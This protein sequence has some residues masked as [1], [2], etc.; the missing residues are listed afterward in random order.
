MLAASNDEM[1]R[2]LFNQVA[3]YGGLL[4]R[5][6]LII[7]NEFRPGNS[8]F[9]MPDKS[10]SFDCLIR[11]LIK[12]SELEGEFKFMPSTQRM[13][14]NWYLPFRE[15]YKGKM[16]K[17]GVLGRIHTHVLKIAMILAANQ[18]SL[19]VTEKHMEVAITECIK[20]LPNYKSFT[21]MKGK[22]TISETGE[23]VILALLHAPGYRMSQNTLL[24]N[25]WQNFDLELLEKL[26]NT[27]QVGGLVQR[28][29]EGN[30]ISFQLTSVGISHFTTDHQVNKSKV[31]E[32]TG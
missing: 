14:N 7:P 20:L 23:I 2:E 27:L 24:A 17:S 22:S 25:N 26:M 15:S 5:T 29:I 19:I 12:I 30:E 21:L 10:K 6:L 13:Y 4:A 8:L 9:D 11:Q 3:I 16:E 32:Q 18:L 31:K 1:I 28:Y